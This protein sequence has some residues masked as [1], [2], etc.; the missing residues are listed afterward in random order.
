MLILYNTKSW[1]FLNIV[2]EKKMAIFQIW[3][4]LFE[5]I[6]NN[7]KTISICQ[8]KSIV[9]GL[10][11]RTT[12]TECCYIY[13][14]PDILLSS[15]FRITIS[16]FLFVFSV[17]FRVPYCFSVDDDRKSRANKPCDPK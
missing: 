1:Q 15:F 5:K 8:R 3:Y 6:N 2:E 16:L 17:F 7:D 10:F 12:P 9:H 14:Q 4:I 13:I 11:H